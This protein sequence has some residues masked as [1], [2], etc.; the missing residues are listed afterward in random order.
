MIDLATLEARIASA[1]CS[2]LLRPGEEDSS[3]GDCDEREDSEGAECAAG[4]LF[5]EENGARSDGDGV[6]QKG[7]KSG[8]GEGAARLV[9]NLEQPG[10]DGVAQDERE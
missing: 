9:A 6:G 5:V 2:S 10:P 8:D 1:S 4:H 3:D 7:R